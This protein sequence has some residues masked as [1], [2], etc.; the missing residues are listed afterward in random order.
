MYKHLWVISGW[1]KQ[2]YYIK[3]VRI[4]KY[5][6]FLNYYRVFASRFI[7]HSLLQIVISTVL[8]SC[9]LHI[10]VNKWQSQL[11]L[12]VSCLCLSFEFNPTPSHKE[13]QNV[14]PSLCIRVTSWSGS[15][16]ITVQTSW[17]TLVVRCANSLAW[18]RCE[19]CPTTLQ[20]NRLVERSHQTIM[21]MIGKL[22]E[23]EKADWPGHLAE[24]VHAYNSTWSAV[25]GYS[26][27]YLMF[28]CRPRFPVNFY[29]PT[30]RTA[31]VP[32]WGA[33][34]KHVDEYV[35]TVW[36]CLRAAP[37]E[38]Q[39]QSM[40]EAQRQKWYYDQNIWHHRFETWQSCPSQGRCL[41][42]K[43]KIMDRWDNKPHE[44]IHQIMT[45][46]PLYDQHG[47][48]LVLHHNWHLLVASGVGIPLLVGVCQV[49]D[50]CTSPPQ[51]SLLLEGVTVRLHH[52]KMMVWQSPSI[53][54]RRLPW[55]G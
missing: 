50:R 12:Y 5:N 36:D 8:P 14:T 24:I 26:P 55:D 15:W 45:D 11:E 10:K 20:T 34:T 49:W 35:A 47:N 2:I 1:F 29:F 39:A 22:G 40:A 6:M 48:S 28:G 27:H 19:P 16:V 32:K 7:L 52:K 3:L 4:L 42:K 30:V 9:V 33:S 54:L 31:E 44:V 18:R 37:Q 53:R 51:S 46:M 41:S 21:W 43:R 17:A 13:S 38:A 23:D 25:M